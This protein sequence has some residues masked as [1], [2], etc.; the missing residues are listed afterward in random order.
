M[1]GV[2]NKDPNLSRTE[3]GIEDAI[4]TASELLFYMEP[5]S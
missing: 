3:V 4:S 5:L 1:Q 2:I